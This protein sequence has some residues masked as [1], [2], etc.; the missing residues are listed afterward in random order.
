MTISRCVSETKLNQNRRRGDMG[1]RRST[2]QEGPWL[3]RGIN[4]EQEDRL[5][6]TKDAHLGQVSREA[7]NGKAKTSEQ[8]PNPKGG[9]GMNLP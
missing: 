1:R 6:W 5:I 7:L 2:G 3:R 4:G 9:A 8:V